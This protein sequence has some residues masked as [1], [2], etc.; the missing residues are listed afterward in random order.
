MSRDM[1]TEGGPPAVETASG[2][3]ELTPPTPSGGLGGSLAAVSVALKLPPFWPANREQWF[4]QVEAQF[5]IISQCLKFD[6]VVL[7]LAPN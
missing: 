3:T 5:G 4:A 1:S 7:S 6:Y 2:G